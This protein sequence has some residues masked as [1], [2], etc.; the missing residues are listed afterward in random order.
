MVWTLAGQAAGQFLSASQ[1]FPGVKQ[2]SAATELVT[3]AV[4]NPEDFAFDNIADHYSD[5]RKDQE[6]R[7]R[8]S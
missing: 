3:K 6:A 4:Q 7:I 1:A 5:I 2:I 8:K